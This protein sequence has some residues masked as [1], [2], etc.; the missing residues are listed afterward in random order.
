MTENKSKLGQ[1]KKILF[2]SLDDISL[3][4]LEEKTLQY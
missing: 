1:S 4:S 2:L 3:H